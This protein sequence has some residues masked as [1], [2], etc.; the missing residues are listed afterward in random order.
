LV[1]STGFFQA[2]RWQAGFLMGYIG[3]RGD[4]TDQAIAETIR[5]IKALSK[6]VPASDFKLKKLDALNSFVFNVD[7]P[8]AL[9][10]TYA[11]YFMRDEPLDTLDR[12]QDQFIS[13]QNED[14]IRLAK[15]Y[16]DTNH[17]QIMIVADK[18]IPVVGP[19]GAQTTLEKS[20][21]QLASRLGLPYR[22]VALR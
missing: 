18:T 4:Q 12:I 20:L 22:E 14:M 9:V 17:L 15:T 8:T 16:L 3:S 19:D 5:I 21:Q 2:Y 6:D 7:S 1:Y 10:S 13:A 11:H